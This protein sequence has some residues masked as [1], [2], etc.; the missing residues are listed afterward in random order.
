MLLVNCGLSA[1]GADQVRS[2]AVHQ[3][4]EAYAAYCQ[5]ANR[6][7]RSCD[8]LLH[9]GL[10]AEAIQMAEEEPVLLELVSTLQF[11]ELAGWE[12]LAAA[13][14]YASPPRLLLQSAE[15]I[16][17]AYA[18]YETLKPL[19]KEHRRLALC[20]ADL[21]KRLA[22]LR[23]LAQMD[24]ASISLAGRFVGL[25][26]GSPTATP[27]GD[28][29]SIQ[30]RARSDG[31]RHL[32]DLIAS[33]WRSPLSPEF[34]EPVIQQ[35]LEVLARRL[36][37]CQKQ[38]DV[39]QARQLLEEWSRVANGTGRT[40]NRTLMRRVES[41]RQMVE[42]D[43]KRNLLELQ[44]QAALLKLEQGI[45]EGC[46]R[47]EIDEAYDQLRRFGRAIPKQINHSYV[48]YVQ[49]LSQKDKRF[50]ITAL[51]VTACVGSFLL[52]GFLVFLILRR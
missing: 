10:R 29:G 42:R 22:V 30:P 26:G 40:P 36:E 7:L 50:E 14:A 37:H 3:M 9:K 20:R 21:D 38:G 25:R 28:R 8:E 51:I 46:N 5:E 23:K 17:R 2:E 44:Y 52:V 16:N 41:V 43:E 12:E 24:S 45:K 31:P 11:P 33:P 18:E 13:Y 15:A 4:S 35:Y 6:R 39:S 48:R 47:E 34:L 1:R 27:H 19:M 49:K 32:H